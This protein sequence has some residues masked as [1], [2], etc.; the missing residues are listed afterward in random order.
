MDLRVP[1]FIAPRA[2][3]C[4]A[5]DAAPIGSLEADVGHTSTRRRPYVDSGESLTQAP[6]PRANPQG[7]DKL[8]NKYIKRLKNLDQA[9]KNN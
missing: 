9:F 7:K 1:A 4:Q 2:T 3:W 8:L 6:E 5:R